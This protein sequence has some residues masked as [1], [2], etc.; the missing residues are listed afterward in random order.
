MAPY[1]VSFL[2][3]PGENGSW[4]RASHHKEQAWNLQPHARFPEKGEGLKMELMMDHPESMGFRE[5]FD[6][7][8]KILGK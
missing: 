8:M 6:E 4:V 2:L 7:H 1:Y 3:S 5:L